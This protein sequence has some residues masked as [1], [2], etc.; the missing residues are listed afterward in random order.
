MYTMSDF[1]FLQPL[2]RLTSHDFKKNRKKGKSSFILYFLPVILHVD[3]ILTI[4][5]AFKSFN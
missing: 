3:S 4:K 1:V 5:N 2:L